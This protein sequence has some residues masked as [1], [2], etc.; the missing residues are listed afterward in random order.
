[1]K[2]PGQCI[3]RLLL[4]LQ[5]YTVSIWYK[6]GKNMIF[7]DHLSRNINPEVSKVPTVPGLNL[8]VSSF[9]LNVSLSKPEHIRQ[10]SECDPQILMLK[11]LIIQ[12]WPKDIK[13]CP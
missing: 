12:G 11:K 13:Q 3:Q 7:A 4:R 9:E 6:P 8:E 5:K 2:R 1:M 10:E